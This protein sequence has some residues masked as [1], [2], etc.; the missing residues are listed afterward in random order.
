MSKSKRPF[1]FRLLS[2]FC[3][4]RLYEE[5]EGDLIYKF[6]KEVKEVGEK[7]AKR[8][9]IWNVVRFFRPGILLRNKFSWQLNFFYMLDHFFKIFIRTTLKNKSY[10]FINISGLAVGLAC[11]IFTLL[12][13]M[14]EFAY[15][16][17]HE[18]KEQVYTFRVNSSYTDGVFT[19]AGTSGRLAEGMKEFPEVEQSARSVPQD[20]LLVNFKDQSFYEQGLYA[21]ASFFNIFTFP[22]KE[23]NAFDQ[24]P[25]ANAV[26]IS[27]K[28]AKKYFGNESAIG[29][30]I[31]INNRYDVRVTAVVKDLPSQSSIQFQLLLPYSIYSK[32]DPYN[33]EWGAWTG[34]DTYV[35]LRAGTD[36]TLLEQ[37][38]SKQ[39]THPKIWP[40][41]GNNV[42][43]V[44]LP[45]T[46]WHLFGNFE[47]GKQSGG[48]IEYVKAFG[49]I[50]IFILLIACVNFMNLATAR[51]VSR[52]KEIGVRKVI[53]A[54]RQSLAG[55]FLG[56]SVLISFISLLVALGIVHLLLPSFN[57]LTDKNVIIDYTNPIVLFG[58]TGIALLT[59]LIAGSYPAFFLSSLRVIQ[60]LKDKLS[61]ASGAGVRKTLVVFQFSLSVILIICAIVVYRQIEYMRD[62]NLGFDKEN[63]FYVKA[64]ESLSKN[65]EAFR[66]ELMSQPGIRSVSRAA[67][68]PMNIQTGLEM[69]DDGWRG[70]TKEDNVRFQWQFC[71]KDFLSAFRFGLVDGRMFSD[72]SAADSTNYII[73]E[74]AA[75]R[76]RLDHPVGEILKVDRK[77]TI[78][79]VVKDFHSKGLDQPI[80][81]VIISMRPR[82]ANQLFIHY[83]K[84]QLT[85]VM[86]Q[87]T[88]TYKKLEPDF[89]M[90][91]TFLD[92]SFDQQY[93]N[94]ILI[95]KLSTYF[96]VVALFISCL[97][98]FGLASFTA[99]RRV[100]EIGIRKVMGATV[101]QLIA[102][103]CRDFMRLIF[104]ALLIGFP[105]AWWAGTLFLERYSFRT[106]FSV[107]I[108]V[109][110]GAALLVI[111]LLTVSYQSAKA[112]LRNPV[113]SLGSE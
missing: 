15:D 77:G 22:L 36:K 108:F 17:F 97:G 1:A 93:K 72:E 20:K 44:L 4:D 41:W 67:D 92:D 32:T 68:E 113:K 106:D 30:M 95:G 82:R 90:E 109:M 9:L 31:K 76:M 81:P 96:M 84:N 24:L 73:N 37:K 57:S 104:I 29:K 64:S 52:S 71:D 48:R 46:D 103:L 25:D 5:I 100:K 11:S 7:S 58:F 16:H 112:A 75:R 79:G 107:Y 74:E 99:E 102:L 111:A 38:I 21:D 66:Q 34:G 83:E 45:L 18:S 6:N 91:Y 33:E 87:V 69:S 101:S 13:V 47:N 49:L 110:T 23:G 12:W 26:V 80:Q 8:R 10:S 88:A 35:K 51:S 39:I 62:K 70:K 54:A 86:S 89:P 42:E 59:G 60:I 78:I 2:W 105:L 55:Q 63:V 85:E 19:F 98:L 27:D 56:E 94:E 53:G 43:L 28:L 3:P 14:D 50:A 65:Y 40:R 61:G